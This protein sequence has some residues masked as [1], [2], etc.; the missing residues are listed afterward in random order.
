MRIDRGSVAFE[1]G[2]YIVLSAAA[3]LTILPFYYVVLIS[4]S[5][6]A[7]VAAQPVYLFPTVIDFSAYKM[8]FEGTFLANGLIVS[9]TLLLVGTSINLAITLS[10]SYVLAKR[11]LPGVKVIT[12]LILFTML[13]NGGLIPFYLTVKGL[14]LINNFF[15]MVLPTAIDT[16]LLIIG[17]AGDFRIMVQVVFPIAKPIIATLLLFYAV[18]RWNE[19]WHAMIFVNDIQLEPLQYLV[20]Q[21]LIQVSSIINSSAGAAMADQ[22][23]N[24]SAQ[25]IKM[26]SVVIS[27]VPILVIYPLLTRYFSQGILLGSLKE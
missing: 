22:I 4:V 14:G 16:F 8:A 20:R 9:T 3:I 1:I 26:A 11:T 5:T 10:A 24:Q 7:A 27:I 19:W 18:Q 25:A 23:K 15:V 2:A 21:L 13:F 12:L 6:P 17:S